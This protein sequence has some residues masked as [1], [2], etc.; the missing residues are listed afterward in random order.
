MFRDDASDCGAI[1]ESGTKLPLR[2]PCPLRS[3]PNRDSTIRLHLSPPAL[4]GAAVTSKFGGISV[5]FGAKL[6]CKTPEVL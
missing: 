5:K 3:R 6:E 2:V 4:I 1:F